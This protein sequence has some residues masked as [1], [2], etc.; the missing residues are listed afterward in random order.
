MPTRLEDYTV[1]WIC[2][3]EIE[4]TIAC[5]LLDKRY[6]IHETPQIDT[7]RDFFAYTFGR[8]HDRNVVV[9]CLSHGYYGI[10]Q[11]DI[12]AERIWASFPALQY[13]LMVGIA[14]GAPSSKN[15]IHLGGH[16]D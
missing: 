11:A 13:R 14:G 16:S 15:D 5:E 3:I 6:A 10:T 4:Y 2:A 12:V 8:I 1:A 9:A 7:P